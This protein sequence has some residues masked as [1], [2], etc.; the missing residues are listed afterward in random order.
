M[1]LGK[2][3][4]IRNEIKKIR[5]KNHDAIFLEMYFAVRNILLE[6]AFTAVRMSHEAMQNDELIIDLYEADASLADKMLAYHEGKTSLIAQLGGKG[7]AAK[8]DEDKAETIRL[9]EAGKVA[10]KWETGR[11]HVPDAA[12]EI[13]PQIVAFSRGK[14]NLVATT[15]MPK[16][17]IKEHLKRCES[18]PS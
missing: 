15:T 7:R 16:S 6:D 4:R 14:G 5:E 18:S 2:K 12:L 3:D 11:H 10:G 8:Y 17:W 13:T 9:Y 1:A